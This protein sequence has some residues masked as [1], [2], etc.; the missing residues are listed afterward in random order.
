[1]A[2]QDSPAEQSESGDLPDDP[3]EHDKQ[4]GALAADGGSVEPDQADLQET[5]DASDDD[6]DPLGPTL[7]IEDAP[8]V[9][10]AESSAAESVG[11]GLIKQIDEIEEG[12]R[13]KKGVGILAAIILLAA[14]I[15]AVVYF[16]SASNTANQVV[17]NRQVSEIDG[18]EPMN[19]GVDAPTP[20]K[21]KVAE[22]AARPTIPGEAVQPPVA[23]TENGAAGATAK[24]GAKAE[25]SAKEQPAKVAV[26]E[27]SDGVAD[28]FE[29]VKGVETDDPA[30]SLDQ[31]LGSSTKRRSSDDSMRSGV[32]DGVA[33]SADLDSPIVENSDVFNSMAAIRT[34]RTD[35]IYSPT[36]S[37]KKRE[38]KPSG[39]G[40]ALSR[41][42]INEGIDTIRKSVGVCRQR[43]TRRGLPLE[44]RKIY[45][46]I[47]VEP[48]GRVSES[49]LAPD[50]LE[51]TEFANCMASHRARWR[52]PSFVGTAQKM[53]APFVLQ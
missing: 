48:S 10:L 21:A 14:G 37:L 22:A 42:E 1:L 40:S 13:S 41:R 2:A 20:E 32:D 19:P 38:T 53:R 51:N 24:K 16:T 17:G 34:D 27:E 45:L 39:I 29:G 43:H 3:I 25:E 49:T 5:S 9:G 12:E 35:S 28:L 33:L 44:A 47:T 52:F 15:G 23:A 18:D 46:T 30:P 4:S 31:V 7:P 36:A 11:A 50:R 8:E 26:A 6:L